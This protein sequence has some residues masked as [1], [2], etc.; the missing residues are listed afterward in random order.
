VFYSNA[1]DSPEQILASTIDLTPDWM[2]WEHA[3]PITVLE[4]ELDYE[5]V[6]YPIVPSRRGTVTEPVHQLRDPCIFE[7]DGN[8]YLLYSVAG[9][10][11]IAIAEIE[12]LYHDAA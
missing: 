11:G 5:G 10:Q 8:I 2:A 7:E 12:S 6:H 4:P 9:E 3:P 1:T